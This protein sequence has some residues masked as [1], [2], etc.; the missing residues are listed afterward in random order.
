MEEHFDIET[1]VHA[2]F[3]FDQRDLVWLLCRGEYVPFRR[4]RTCHI[5]EDGYMDMPAVCSYCGT[6]YDDGRYCKYCG[7]KVVEE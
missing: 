2:K 7:A 1:Y 4:E 5:I 3:D 6:P